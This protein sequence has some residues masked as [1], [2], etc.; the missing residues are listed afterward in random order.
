MDSTLIQRYQ[1]GNDIYNSILAQHG[2]D[3]ADACAAAA[4]TGDETQIN[5]VLALY[6]G[7]S[8][9]TVAVPMADTST[10]NIFTNQILTDPL[11]APL[12]SA[13][14]VLGNT[15]FSFLKNPW[16]VV[17]V[18]IVVFFFVFDGVNLI[19]GW[20]KKTT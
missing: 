9:P 19:R 15:F 5:A 16:V 12:E 8:T 17:T 14:K 1:P 10:A 2:K 13:N 20:L 3:A 18:G 4:M 11:A 6:S 7:T